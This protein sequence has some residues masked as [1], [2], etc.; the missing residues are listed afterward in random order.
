MNEKPVGNAKHSIGLELLR[1]TSTAD[2]AHAAPVIESPLLSFYLCPAAVCGKRHQYHNERTDVTVSSTIE[3]YLP[4]AALATKLCRKAYKLA[5]PHIKASIS[6]VANNI[7]DETLM[8]IDGADP[9]AHIDDNSVITIQTNLNQAEG[10]YRESLAVFPL[11]EPSILGHI[12]VL[13]ALGRWDQALSET[14]SIPDIQKSRLVTTEIVALAA[15]SGIILS[16]NTAWMQPHRTASTSSEIKKA[17]PAKP[18]PLDTSNI[19][20]TSSHLSHPITIPPSQTPL[21]LPLAAADFECLLCYN[22]LYDPVTCPCGH[23]WCRP[24]LL[25][26]TDHNRKCPLCRAPL[27]SYG[28]YLRRQPN[29]ILNKIITTYYPEPT[30][31]RTVSLNE[32]ATGPDSWI[33]MFICTLVYPGM[34]CFLH[35]FEPRYRILVKR[36]METDKRFG[37]VLPSSVGAFAEYGTM[38]EIRRCEPI[39][40]PGTDLTGDDDNALP[41]YLIDT[42]GI[43]RFKVLERSTNDV[44][45]STARIERL[46]DIDL[47]DEDPATVMS[48]NSSNVQVVSDWAN[49]WSGD[50]QA[51]TW[52]SSAAATS[53]SMD[54]HSDHPMGEHQMP[55]NPSGI[56][57]K[58]ISQPTT[59]SPTVPPSQPVPEYT[60]EPLTPPP[61]ASEPSHLSRL[62]TKALD[63]IHNFIASLPEQSRFSFERQHGMPPADPG[64]LSFWLASLLPIS[65]TRKY[66]LLRMQSVVGRMEKVCHLID[67]AIEQQRNA[68]GNN[69]GGGAAP[70]I[71]NTTNPTTTTTAS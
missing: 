45:F 41:R 64:D 5:A 69:P 9:F 25:E 28:H 48:S 56:D 50:S 19:P 13:A 68:A 11:L 35:I 71:P 6:G 62:V 16:S 66:D 37:V 29:I 40:E 49:R 59:S 34:P 17:L 12:R 55:S 14:R 63:F 47:E 67:R 58:V 39:N 8:A 65:P 10:L 7:P 33:P 36:A 2:N 26:S 54:E 46:E 23:T 1:T 60:A 22:L 3:K 21:E 15:Q 61:S 32:R 24:C 53:T 18:A 20:I 52:S 44:G 30:E 70:Q 57:H 42:I 4:E 27:A 43:Y 38:V 31:A 51:T